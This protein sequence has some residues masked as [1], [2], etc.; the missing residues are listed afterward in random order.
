MGSSCRGLSSLW[1]RSPAQLYIPNPNHLQWGQLHSK[2]LWRQM[3]EKHRKHKIVDRSRNN[4]LI[5]TILHSISS[6]IHMWML[7]W[8]L[9]IF[10]W[11]C[12]H[13]RQFSPS[14]CMPKVIL[15]IFRGIEWQ[16]ECKGMDW[17]R[18][19]IGPMHWSTKRIQMGGEEDGQK[20]HW[21]KWQ[22][23]MKDFHCWI[24]PQRK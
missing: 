18:I 6:L 15:P 22:I 5:Y 13:R 9:L 8:M 11:L 21:K 2:T 14:S 23:K 20:W 12:G 4:N 1:D 7:C 10:R 16:K 19:G 24:Y 3:T 17:M